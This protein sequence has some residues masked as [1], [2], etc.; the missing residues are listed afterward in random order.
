MLIMTRTCYKIE[1][2]LTIHHNLLKLQVLVL[3]DIRQRGARMGH[4]LCHNTIVRDLE[5]IP[6]YITS[7]HRCQLFRSRCR[8]KPHPAIVLHNRRPHLSI[9]AQ[10]T[11][12]LERLYHRDNNRKVESPVGTSTSL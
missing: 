5:Y 6:I 4:D 10:L 7:I 9:N 12:V 2:I 1:V 3:P 11:I 8:D